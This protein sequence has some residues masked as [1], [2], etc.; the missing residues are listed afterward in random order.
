VHGYLSSR[1]Q[2][3]PN[4][5]ALSRTV[6]PVIVE[7][8]GHGRSPTPEDARAYEPA[9]YVKQFENIR[10]DLGPEQWL[11]CG[12]SLGA[13]LTLRY[14]LDHPA[15]IVAQV[16]TNSM[17]AFADDGWSERVRPAM[18]AQ[19]R[20][21]ETGGHAAVES[22]P[23]NPLRSRRLSTEVRRAFEDDVA[24]HDPVGLARTGLYTVPDSPVRTR[25]TENSVPS[26]LVAGDRELR[27]ADQRAFAE[28][29]M[30]LLRVVQLDAGHAVNLD[31]AEAFNAAVSTFFAE[32]APSGSWDKTSV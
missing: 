18:A 7:L 31:A 5:D 6:Q 27:F 25:I 2:W 29:S 19:A 9:A 20:T 28:I 12:Q 14:A 13:A 17:S 8:F 21:L 32:H 15:R 30:P 10:V 26:L 3:L 16:F 23:L 24:L 1:T 22:H 4:L 11:I